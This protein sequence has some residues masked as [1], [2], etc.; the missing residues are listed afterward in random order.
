[1]GLRGVVSERQRRFGEEL[2]RLRE[3]TGMSGPEIGELMGMKGPAVSHTEAGRLSLNIERLH[4]WLDVC[5]MTDPDYRAGLTA[6]CQGTGRGWWSDYRSHVVPGALDLAEFEDAA[7]AFSNYQTQLI[8]GLLQTKAYSEV[9]HEYADKKVEFRL[10][11]QQVI[12]AEHATPF[13]AVIHEAA[14]HMMFGGP[15]VMR[16]QMN[17]LIEMALLPRVTIQILPFD[18]TVYASTDTAF[19]LMHGPHSRLDTVVL[20]HPHGST[21]LGDSEGVAAFRRKFDRLKGMALPPLNANV[22]GP[23]SAVRDSWGMIQHVRYKLLGR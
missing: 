2:R 8:P 15:A 7:T 6:M 22:S 13:H 17:H 11:R 18:C 3:A 4:V 21:F 1:M 9:I 12:T 23:S 10:R 19:M 20:E 14:L 5:G 16:E